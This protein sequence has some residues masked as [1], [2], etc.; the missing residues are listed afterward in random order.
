MPLQSRQWCWLLEKE[1]FFREHVSVG[2]ERALV[3]SIGHR[4]VKLYDGMLDRNAP[5]WDRS[6]ETWYT[7]TEVCSLQR[8]SVGFCGSSLC[9]WSWLK[10]TTVLFFAMTPQHGTTLHTIDI[11]LISLCQK[12][13]GH[14]WK[15]FKQV[16][17]WAEINNLQ[18][19]ALFIEH[20]STLATYFHR[21]RSCEVSPM[22]CEYNQSP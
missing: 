15:E 19:H 12:L 20:V 10:D 2:T 22:P 17:L 4:T 1:S 7:R 6:A 3:E 11:Y 5:C 9:L 14:C 16:H 18:N 21:R 13:L 8:R